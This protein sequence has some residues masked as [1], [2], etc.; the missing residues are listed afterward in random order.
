MPDGTGSWWILVDIDL[1]IDVKYTRLN[2]IAMRREWA[3][4]SMKYAIK[5]GERD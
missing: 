2:E 3:S 4:M 1:F 5:G